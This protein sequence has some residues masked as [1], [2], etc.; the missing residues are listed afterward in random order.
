MQPTK[1]NV[2]TL[3][4]AIF[5]IVTPVAAQVPATGGDSAARTVTTVKA[6][7]GQAV[8]TQPS[9]ITRMEVRSDDQ[10]TRIILV[11]SQPFTPDIR[12]YA[13]PSATV[14]T[15]SGTWNAGRRGIT[16]VRKNGVLSIRAGQFTD[17]PRQVRIV[18]N[19][20][21]IL[22]FR[23]EP[24]ADRTRWE[25]VLN[26]APK[27]VAAVAPAPVV[28]PA[29]K[30]VET[31]VTAPIVRVAS[32]IVT[33]QKTSGKLA[34]PAK[35]AVRTIKAVK[36]YPQLLTGVKPVVT[37]RT[38]A[39][40]AADIAETAV[41]VPF[42][43]ASTTARRTEEAP[44]E[45][46]RVSLD[47]VAADINDVLKALSLQSGIN[48]VTST[49][50]KGN[51]TC[52]LRRVSFREAL[53]TV[54]NLSGYRYARINTT[55]AV[56]SADAVAK[57]VQGASV[58]VQI[59]S[60]IPFIFSDG[61]SLKEAI[62]RAFPAVKERVS[63][64]S[65][66]SEGKTAT[67]NALSATNGA[68]G[69]SPAA[70]GAPAAG[71]RTSSSNTSTDRMVVE[72]VVPKGGVIVVTGTQIEVNAIQ[73]FVDETEKALLEAP[74]KEAQA[75]A[76]ENALLSARPTE[77][78]VIRYSSAIDLI[79]ALNRL[80]PA[81]SVQPGPAQGFQP[82]T[83]GGSAST[84]T[85]TPVNPITN[86]TANG[87]NASP[88]G[89]AEAA[90]G[91]NT[92]VS[93]NPSGKPGNTLLL[94]GT[95]EAIARAREVLTQI[96]IKVPQIVF[97]ARIVETTQENTRDLGLTYDVGRIITVGEKDQGGLVLNA[98]APARESQVGAIFRSPYTIDAKLF[99]LEQK[100]KARTLAKPNFTAIDGTPGKAFIG[101]QI[102]Y[103]VNIQQTPQGQIVQ[104]ETASVGITLNCT[105]KTSPDGS[106]TVYVHPE[107]SII[108]GFIEAGQVRLPQIATRYV[109][110][111]VRVKDGETFALGGLIR[112]A[113][114]D[115]LSK[116]PLIGD[117][118][119]LG[120]LFQRRN[121]ERRNTEILI[122]VTTRLLK[123]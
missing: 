2:Y 1:Q 32:P 122:F 33:E 27:A 5:G 36:T 59:T 106:I 26:T 112:Q 76:R 6:A 47:F 57:L 69:G 4:L 71:V 68:V 12:N 7:S 80:V 91:A 111:T 61:V 101:D 90:V 40:D 52:S 84:V 14:I 102:R 77:V 113:D 120:Q 65:V 60:T 15:I 42:R 30:P 107:I 50:V 121:R 70:N 83:L 21:R 75:K 79:S 49:D 28:K 87:Q 39:A 92:S 25:I 109:D 123:D 17:T 108:S 64:V 38:V 11:G 41:Q 118:P 88:V 116:V 105:G 51:V 96:D 55:Y 94:T 99:A 23:A 78:Y 24:S 10:E 3:A 56:G 89:N 31:P 53:D 74:A 82:N 45:G 58:G 34:L 95:T 73:Q 98:K 100:N 72:K 19:T 48:I 93:Q 44:E 110:A 37:T 54:V 85:N 66:G 43:T 97:E 22:P 13:R 18:A 46:R 20:A 8:K 29:V 81:V 62:E 103:V 67:A 117:L 35:P 114:V 86:A 9:Q 63:V 119:I 104:T 115:N 16:P